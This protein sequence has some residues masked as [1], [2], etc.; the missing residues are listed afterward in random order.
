MKAWVQRVVPS[1]P[2]LLALLATFGAPIPA[3]AL[4]LDFRTHVT[5]VPYHQLSGWDVGLLFV[6]S[7][8]QL[9]PLTRATRV[10][11]SRVFDFDD[12]QCTTLSLAHLYQGI[13]SDS[14]DVE[15]VSLGG[16][17]HGTGPL[18]FCLDVATTRI[19]DGRVDSDGLGLILGLQYHLYR[20]GRSSAFVESLLGILYAEDILDRPTDLPEQE[21]ITLLGLLNAIAEGNLD[22]LNDPAGLSQSGQEFLL[23]ITSNI[24]EKPRDWCIQYALGLVLGSAD[25]ESVL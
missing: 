21:R 15:Q 14:A 5:E 19:A 2:G 1:L 22:L 6:K 12:G 13:H 17:H 16:C 23:N 9:R 8:D 20:C 24:P 18:A 4:D 7:E 25:L 10:E 3:L 11:F